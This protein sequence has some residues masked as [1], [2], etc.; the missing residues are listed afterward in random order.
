MNSLDY[1]ESGSFAPTSLACQY[2]AVFFE[3]FR[4]AEHQRR[5]LEDEH[6]RHLALTANRDPRELR[7]E[8][9]VYQRKVEKLE[10]WR[11]AAFDV[12][13]KHQQLEH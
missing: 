13:V 3:A 2:C 6:L 8:E 1:S 4:E 10:R 9:E 11:N 5:D 12:L 7:L